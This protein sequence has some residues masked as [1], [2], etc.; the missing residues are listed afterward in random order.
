[1]FVIHLENVLEWGINKHEICA[2]LKLFP[3]V[4]TA[5]T[6]IHVF[7]A[8]IIARIAEIDFFF[9]PMKHTSNMYIY[10]IF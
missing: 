2:M 9:N 8:G 1:M 5:L 4:P 10:Y 7:K 6:Q 3:N